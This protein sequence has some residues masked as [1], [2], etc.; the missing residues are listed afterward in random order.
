MVGG[1]LADGRKSYDNFSVHDN[2]RYPSLVLLLCLV[3]ASEQY[4]LLSMIWEVFHSLV[5]S[6]R[7]TVVL[8]LFS[9]LSVS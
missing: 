5:F 1:G 8:I 7:V 3:L 4:W 2:K 9:S 6:G